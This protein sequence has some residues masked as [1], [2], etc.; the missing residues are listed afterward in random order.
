MKKLQSI[1]FEKFTWLVLPVFAFILMLPF[2]NPE[3]VIRG[4]DTELH[5][6]RVVGFVE[7]LKS[8]QIPAKVYPNAVNGF[9]Y[10]WGIFYP[11]LS[12]MVPG[13]FVM[14]GLD[15]DIAFKLFLWITLSLS[16]VF[17]YQLVMDLSE[18][19]EQSLVTALLYI[20]CPYLLSDIIIRSA[21]GESL[22]FVFLPLLF[23][24]FYSL[25]YG[26]RS[27]AYWVAVGF[28]GL[29]FSHVIGLVLSVMVSAVFLLFHLRRLWNWGV[30][31]PLL[32]W[33]LIAVLLS[34]GFLVP[35]AEHMLFHDYTIEHLT[36]TELTYQMSAYPSQI[37]SSEFVFHMSNY[38]GDF[39]EMPFTL[40][41]IS[42]GL[43]VSGLLVFR[44]LISHRLAVFY[45]AALLILGATIFMS[46]VLFPWRQAGALAFIQFPWRFLIFSVFFICLLNGWIFAEL[47]RGSI[48][49]VAIALL[50]LISLVSVSPLLDIYVHENIYFKPQYGNYRYHNFMADEGV[51]YNGTF[52][53]G[54]R[55]YFPT[56]VDEAFLRQRGDGV[57]VLRG[58][59][60]V[61]DFERAGNQLS[62]SIT[63][64]DAAVLELPLIFYAGYQVR[65]TDV[66]GARLT[67]PAYESPNHLVA[68]DLGALSAGEARVAYRGT[69]PGKIGFY[70]SLVGWLGLILF[71]LYTKGIIKQRLS[72]S[73]A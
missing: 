31:K 34:A 49:P 45:L 11:P 47:N 36:D 50:A 6:N 3:L 52:M 8:G 46:T 67:L 20:T 27:K 1:P 59:A 68:V 40:G 66:N 37:F 35:L 39:E 22:V 32:I 63:G 62:F 55:E 24:G 56:G 17:M 41:L 54:A 18:S 60:M 5:L 13:A 73:R 29:A 72:F 69:L 53:G 19:K 25:L 30:I 43:L 12:V 15:L 61:K 16:G 65:I 14:L 23:R 64:A 70:A 9:G 2:L 57:T 44:S 4:H 71:G 26:D 58:S 33:S 48:Q 10:G 38:L 28:A 51:I 21:V 7:A 42:L